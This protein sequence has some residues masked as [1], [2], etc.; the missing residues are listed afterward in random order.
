MP[1]DANRSGAGAA[2]APA[3]KLDS[4]KEI[5]AYLKR[6]IRTV[7]RWEKYEGLPAHRHQ[8]AKKPTVYA[9]KSELDG[10]FRERQPRDDPAAD[11]AFEPEPDADERV[12][13]DEE[14]ERPRAGR[15]S[16]PVS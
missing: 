14:Q 7:Q 3:E 5:A 15:R 2:P 12:A 13:T 1:G 9:F 8:H 6:D 11:A 16:P 4:W 10:W